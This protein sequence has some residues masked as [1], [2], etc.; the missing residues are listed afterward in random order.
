[1]LVAA[2]GIDGSEVRKAKEEIEVREREAAGLLDKSVPS[3]SAGI[4]NYVK[5][6]PMTAKMIRKLY[7]LAQ[8]LYEDGEYLEA[9]QR[10]T[11]AY[12][13]FG[14]LKNKNPDKHWDYLHLL[15]EITDSLREA[16]ELIKY[17]KLLKS[18]SDDNEYV[19]YASTFLSRA[20]KLK[21]KYDKAL[22]YAH[23]ALEF[24]IKEYG[25]EASWV[26]HSYDIIGSVYHEKKDYE[27]AIE[28]FKKNLAI[29]LKN[30][31]PAH[32]NVAATYNNIALVYDYKK[33][34][35]K[36]NDYYE[37]SLQIYL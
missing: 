29:D 10:M 31:G 14:L 33:E 1:M 30:N 8:S 28:Y 23:E 18:I 36:A 32:D 6:V 13:S 9:K 21:G 37:K 5:P 24:F 12:A 11:K 4:E 17:A 2:C 26:S 7:K 15:C 16:D 3:S 25:E 22:K 27:K 34:Y 19:S 20:H 35:K